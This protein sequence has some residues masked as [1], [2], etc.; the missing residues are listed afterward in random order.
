MAWNGAKSVSG[1]TQSA[2]RVA[3][4]VRVPLANEV[5]GAVRTLR[6]K[7]M[8]ASEL[9]PSVAPGSPPRGGGACR[10]EPAALPTRCYS[11]PARTSFVD[12]YRL[13]G[14]GFT[15]TGEVVG[16]VWTRIMRGRLS[17]SWKGTA[18]V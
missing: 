2:C 7:G 5:D 17:E 6:G 14:M 12:R 1:G 16:A 8:A 3:E 13:L 4:D 11:N 9:P 10:A 18:V 15:L